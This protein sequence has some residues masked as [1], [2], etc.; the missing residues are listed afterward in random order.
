MSLGQLLRQERERRG[1]S[2]A[3][4]AKETRV[5]ARHLEAIE[6]GDTRTMP[7]DFFYRSFVRQ[8][9]KYLGMDSKELETA[10]DLDMGTPAPPA[11][12]MAM[13][14]AAS[15]TRVTTIMKPAPMITE[16]VTP[17]AEVSPRV[18]LQESRTSAPWLMLAGLLLVASISYLAWD[19]VSA[20]KPNSET[21]TTRNQSETET[22][23]KLAAATK[24]PEA[25]RPSAPTVTTTAPNGTVIEATKLASGSLKLIISAKEPAWIQLDA[26]GKALF[27]GLLEPGQT[28]EVE[29]AQQAKLLT[30]N[31]GGIEVLQNGKPVTGL[32]SRGEV[33]T[34]VFSRGEYRVI[35]PVVKTPETKTDAPKSDSSPVAE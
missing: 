20:A 33:R 12:P 14:A 16:R 3:E 5:S 6:T 31:A 15:S 25:E 30:G 32:G 9:G 26:D 2:L 7:R 21:A 1:V 24:A 35:Q 34:V 27:V 19:R 23:Q 22:V 29:N 13:A 8:Y 11:E 10:L 28:R 18:F 4:I 17:T